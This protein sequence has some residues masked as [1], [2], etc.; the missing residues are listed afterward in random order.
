MTRPSPRVTV[1]VGLLLAIQSFGSGTAVAGE[2]RLVL[3]GLSFFAFE[4]ADASALIPGETSI[5]VRIEPGRS[6]VWEI[7]IPADRFEVPPIRYPS[8]RSVRWKLADAARGTLTSTESGLM[9]TIHAPLIAHLDGAPDGVSFPLTFTTE[10]SSRAAGTLVASREGVRLDP[11]S[12]YVQLVATGLNPLH[13]D[14]AP[15]SPF[16]AVLSGRF[17]DLPQSMRAP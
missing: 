6:G 3:D 14:T 13:A 10:R 15:G 4:G 7:L 8:G 9:C 11:K 17:L 16:T 5:P 12:G 2:P 1:V